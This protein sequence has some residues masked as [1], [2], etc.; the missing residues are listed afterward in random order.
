V[1]RAHAPR[2]RPAER[3]L[4]LGLCHSRLPGARGCRRGCRGRASEKDAKLAQNGPA[5]I[6]W[7]DLTP[8]SP[9]QAVA[10]KQNRSRKQRDE[11]RVNFNTAAVVEW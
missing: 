2:A 6:F 1:T 8:F 9:G 7:A 3:R 10:V 5:C 4:A 11:L